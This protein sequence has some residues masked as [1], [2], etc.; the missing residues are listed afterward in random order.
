MADLLI[1]NA[2]LVDGSGSPARMA[3]VIVD[4]DKID[5]ITRHSAVSA[6]PPC[7]TR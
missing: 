5:N 2:R 1:R 3:D 6:S 4:G 7:Q